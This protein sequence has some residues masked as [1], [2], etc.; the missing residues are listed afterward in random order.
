MPIAATLFLLNGAT[1]AAAQVEYLGEMSIAKQFKMHS[2]KLRRDFQ[3]SV[4]LPASYA[5]SKK[6]YG[7][8]ILL[9]GKRYLPATSSA[10]QALRMDLYPHVPELIIV[11]IDSSLRMRDFTA[12]NFVPEFAKNQA[13]LF[14]IYQQS[15]GAEEFLKF[16]AEELKPYLQNKYRICAP[17]IMI[18]HSLAGLF[19]IYSLQHDFVDAAISIDPSLWFDYPHT[20]HCLLQTKTKYKN[21]IFAYANNQFSPGVGN[22]KSSTHINRQF[23]ESI[24]QWTQA[25]YMPDANHYNI[26]YKVINQALVDLFWGYY[27][28]IAQASFKAKIMLKQYAKLNQRLLAHFKI[29]QQAVQ[30]LIAKQQRSKHLQINLDELKKLLLNTE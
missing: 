21:L 10:I 19:S 4:H 22:S 2:P 7:L 28:D 18:G 1:M 24:D 12:Q 13:A 14:N 26:F 17:N 9:D 29:E 25:I 27:A 11:G 5:Q 23:A 20:F 16:L 3:L 15:G 8:I 30:Q 6:C